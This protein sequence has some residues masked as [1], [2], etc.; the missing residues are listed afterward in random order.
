MPV[1]GVRRGVTCSWAPLLGRL[2]HRPDGSRRTAV[3]SERP[4]GWQRKDCNCARSAYP[5]DE[6]RHRP[7]EARR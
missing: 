1:G 3:A 2:E 7:M 4:E 6:G 5:R